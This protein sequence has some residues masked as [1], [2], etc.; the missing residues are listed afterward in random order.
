[1]KKIIL[2]LCLVLC[3]AFS[4]AQAG[5]DPQTMAENALYTIVARTD[6]GDMVLGSGVLFQRSDALLTVSHCM[7]EGTEIYAVNADGERRVKGWETLLDSGLGILYLEGLART[8][9]LAL[10]AMDCYALPTLYGV[11]GKGQAAQA[12]LHQI[13]YSVHNGY[14]ALQLV[15]HDGL[16]PGGVMMDEKGALMGVILTQNGEGRG[17]YTALDARTL[18]ALMGQESVSGEMEYSMT[19]LN[20][21][22]RET[23]CAWNGDKGVAVVLWPEAEGGEGTYVIHVSG[24]ENLYYTSYTAEMGETYVELPLPPGHRYLFHVQWVKDGEQAEFD[25]AYAVSLEIPEAQA[26]TSYG[27][28]QDCYLGVA[29]AAHP[30]NAIHDRMDEVSADM[31]TDPRQTVCLQILNRYDVDETVE[32]PL[33]IC[34]EAPDGQFYWYDSSYAFI[35][36]YEQNDVFCM[37]LSGLWEDCATFSGHAD[38]LVPAGEYTLAYYIG[39]KLAGEYAFEVKPAGAVTPAASPDVGFVTDVTLVYEN[40]MV[41]LDWTNAA[42]LPIGAVTY[43]ANM[44]IDQNTYSSYIIIPD[45]ETTAQFLHVPDSYCAY[46]VTWA[47]EGGNALEADPLLQA[48]S[49]QIVPAQEHAPYGAHGF[50]HIRSSFTVG[51]ACDGVYREEA[52]ITRELLMGSEPL[53]YQTEDAYQV[54]DADG[55]HPMVLAL[56]TPEG[57]VFTDP[58]FYGFMPELCAGDIWARD[59]RPLLQRYMDMAADAWPAGDYD[60][61]CWIDGCEAARISFTLPAKEPA[62]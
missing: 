40:G 44:E 18:M 57:Y 23:L 28:T 50:T 25:M 62:E 1:M 49:F 30:H 22:C 16:M 17:R 46:W 43:Y 10:S 13:I 20:G 3:A 31:L 59:V 15:A 60:F 12:H 54:E 41:T 9:P 11:D 7:P 37:D 26:L 55:D 36:E 56:Y 19:W 4:V 24:E 21:S 51:E 58:A 45:G 2:L 47:R 6:G 53:C 32:M 5:D 35:P 42:D 39:G 14:N 29:P 33:S 27:F 8:A 34:L 52:A 38:G 61:V 48:N